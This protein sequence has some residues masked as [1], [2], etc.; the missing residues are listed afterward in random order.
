MIVLS[1]Y[2]SSPHPLFFPSSLCVFAAHH[3]IPSRTCFFSLCLWTYVCV[4]MWKVPL[5]E[6]NWWSHSWKAKAKEK[7]KT[8]QD[9]SF[10]YTCFVCLAPGQSCRSPQLPFWSCTHSLCV[11]PCLHLCIQARIVHVSGCMPCECVACVICVRMSVGWFGCVWE[12][13][14]LLNNT[15]EPC[16]CRAL[17]S[18]LSHITQ[19]DKIVARILSQLTWLNKG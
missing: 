1:L 2:P 12:I 5:E 18:S 6:Q 4:C 7:K 15:E 19:T 16:Q 14:P 9:S 17:V 3:T 13:T 11:C 10:C 8:T